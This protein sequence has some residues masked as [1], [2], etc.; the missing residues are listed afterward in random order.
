MPSN[1]RD[2]V[3]LYSPHTDADRFENA[4]QCVRN[5]GIHI[6][7]LIDSID[8]RTESAYTGWPERLYVIAAGGRIVYKSEPGPF[9]FHPKAM[10]TYLCKAL[11]QTASATY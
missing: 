8:D 10:E 7:A 11:G 4:G 2:H 6:P 5:L 3:L 1:E 9:G